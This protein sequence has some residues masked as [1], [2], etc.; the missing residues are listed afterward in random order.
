MII[1]PQYKGVL[2]INKKISILFIILFF[3]FFISLKN[4]SSIS[5]DIYALGEN[6]TNYP[7]NLGPLKLGLS[8]S[9]TGELT[10][11]I[12]ETTPIINIGGPDGGDCNTYGTWDSL[13]WTCTLNQNLYPTEYVNITSNDVTLDCDGYSISTIGAGFGF[14]LLS[15]TNVTVKNCN[16]SDNFCGILLEDSNNITLANNSV[17]SNE[18]GGIYLFYSSS[19]RLKNNKMMNNNQ[20]IVIIGDAKEHYNHSIDESNTVNGKPVKYYFENCPTI[21]ENQNITHLTLAFCSNVIVRY[22]EITDGDWVYLAFVKDSEIYSNK[23]S[24]TRRGIYLL[25]SSNITIYNNSVSSNILGIYFYNSSGNTIKNNIINSNT[26]GIYLVYSHNNTLTNNTANSNSFGIYLSLSNN[27]MLTDNNMINNYLMNLVVSGGEKE[28]YNNSIDTSN[29]IDNIPVRYYYKNCDD[30]MIE[31]QELKHLTLVDCENVTVRNISM[32][33][34]DMI[35]LIFTNDSKIYSNYISNNYYGIKMENSSDNNITANIICNNDADFLLTHS[36]G[37]YGNDNACFKARSWNDTGTT[38]C[39]HTCFSTPFLFWG[40]LHGHTSYSDGKGI[41]YEYYLYC[42]DSSKLDFC[43]LTDHS[44]QIDITKWGD[45]RN[46]ATAFLKNGSFVSFSGFEWTSDIYGYGHKP[47]YFLRDNVTNVCKANESGC[48]TPDEL[49]RFLAENDGLSHLAHPLTTTNWDYFNETYQTNAEIY[50]GREF[51]SDYSINY[52]LQSG[53]RFGLVGVSDT[54]TLEPGAGYLTACRADHL[55]RGD[56]LN[57]LRNRK[58]YATSGVRIVLDFTVD[59]HPMGSEFI[60]PVNTNVTANIIVN[61]TTNI[62]TIEFIKNGNIIGTKSD[63]GV[64]CIYSL[65]TTITEDSYIYARVNQRERYAWS[66]PIWIV[67]SDD[68]DGDGVNNSEDNCIYVYNP[69]QADSD[70]GIP[71]GMISYWKFDEGSGTIA[72][73]SADANNG[74]IYGSVWTTGRVNSALRFDGIDDY[75][76]VSDNLSLDFDGEVTIEAWFRK[77]STLNSSGER[78]VYKVGLGEERGKLRGYYTSVHPDGKYRFSLFADSN[79]DLWGNTS[80]LADGDWHHAVA[81]RD[82]DNMM[83]IYID[84]KLDGTTQGPNGTIRNVQPLYIGQDYVNM[85]RFKGLLDEVAIYNRTLTPEEIKQHYLN[86]LNGYGY[87]GDGIGNACDNCW[88]VLNPNQSDSN[89]NCPLPP[90]ETDP[91]CGDVCE[92]VSP[93]II[94]ISSPQNKT[95]YTTSVPLT[96]TVNEPVSWCGYSLDRNANV[97]ISPCRNITLTGLSYSTHNIIVYANDTSGNMGVSNRV[98][99]TVSVL[100]CT[101]T[102]WRPTSRCCKLPYSQMYMRTC[103]PVG[104]DITQVCMKGRCTL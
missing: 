94:T 63:C 83:Y 15:K 86:G 33:N 104:C 30:L 53:L 79:T 100:I 61:G 9:K 2:K 23:V 60:H 10:S 22:N 35:K 36:F 65:N 76:N 73:D 58:C 55:T 32:S 82:T 67:A 49:Y 64:N 91:K 25:S 12:L 50:S 78:V 47:S 97:T 3:S 28:D 81:I 89:D 59:E 40:D 1:A 34:G 48:D 95:Y 99:F 45:M 54:H 6:E 85:Y 72:K 103:N 20:G 84:G 102:A 19:V 52:A 38:G 11:E 31:N 16:V 96:F 4:V 74:T 75:I 37:N 5:F 41:P 77:N 88:Y 13:T 101:C 43:A 29:V 93:P 57:S 87:T 68:I 39:S 42:R 46:Q 8:E 70:V 21:I 24:N 56:I 17:D 7:V 27:N 69:D 51:D 71:E 90:Y 80:G 92:D 66:S 26:Y 44:E 62:T 18:F 14:Y 98:Y